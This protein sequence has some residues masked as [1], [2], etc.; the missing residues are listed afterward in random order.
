[1]HMVSVVAAS[2]WW[3]REV[4]V[5]VDETTYVNVTLGR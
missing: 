1:M 5:K 3:K 4:E 2:G